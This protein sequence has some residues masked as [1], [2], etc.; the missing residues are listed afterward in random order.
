M[1]VCVTGGAGF[2]GDA[3]CRALRASGH[4]AIALDLRPMAGATH[5]F[6]PVDVTDSAA[7]SLTL[8]RLRPDAVVHLAAML[9]SESQA[10]P[11]AATRVNVLGTAIVFQAALAAGA[12]RVV[13]ASSVAALGAADTTAGDAATPK[14]ASIYGATKA[15]SE[16]LA[17]AIAPTSQA[18]LVGL[19][20]GWIYGPGRVR[21]WRAPQIPIEA[22]L[23]GERDVRY[24]DYPQAID[25]TWIQDAAM[26]VV[27]AVEAEMT[28]HEVFNVAGDR[29]TMRDAVAILAGHFPDT[30][31]TP[32]AAITPTSAWGFAN[33]GLESALGL[34]PSTALEAGIGLF[35]QAWRDAQRQT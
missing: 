28:G 1:R 18:S 29:R 21:G 30:L 32:E 22:A 24:Q 3:A 16:H 26:V 25:W 8:A 17:G 13:Y 19:R 33:D 7:A 10:D 2:L 6:Q 27:R 31:F 9:T 15:F 4:E 11:V 35:M 14:P 5:P 20:F 34:R 12:R 23:R